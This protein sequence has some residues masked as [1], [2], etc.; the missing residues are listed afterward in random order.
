MN[1]NDVPISASKEEDEN[2]IKVFWSQ[3]YMHTPRQARR[4]KVLNPFLI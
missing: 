2:E 3:T 1:F 4:W